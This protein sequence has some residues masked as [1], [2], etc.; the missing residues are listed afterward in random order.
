MSL[1][2]PRTR[3]VLPDDLAATEPPERRGLARDGVRLLVATPDGVR[4]VRFAD[5]P[6]QLGAGDLVV[7]NT[8]ATLPAALDGVRESTSTPVVVHVA[9]PGDFVDPGDPDLGRP[10]HL[11]DPGGGSPSRLP[12]V[13]LRRPDGSGGV[14]DARAGEVVTLP[15]GAAVTLQTPVRGQSHGRP[16]LWHARLRPGSAPTLADL[17]ERHGRPI[18]YGYVHGRWPLASYQTVFGREPGSTE[19]P[20]AGRPFT[21]RLV[22]DLA[23]RGIAVAP[24]LLHTGVSSQDHG[25]PPQP[26]TF[27]VPA[28]TARLVDHTRR[29]GG[30]VVAV[31]TT[32]TRALESAAGPNGCVTASGGRTDLVLGPGRTARVV[33]GLVTGWHAP[34][35]SHLSL[36][37][38][39]AGPALVGAAYRAALDAGYLWHELGDACLLLPHR[40]ARDH[41]AGHTPGH[42]RGHDRGGR[43]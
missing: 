4:H 23:V 21:D 43:H 8:S 27:R 28:A 38:A 11:G 5:L 14:L 7:V 16:R 34:E 37:E 10:G 24:V 2:P 36:L 40:P 12:V 41:A 22:T 17:L 9:D 42:T 19:M 3:F 30:R 15:A 26:E 13:E 39:V 29:H 25:E 35:A 20:S 6:S 32:V 31:G 1:A 33:D 18:T